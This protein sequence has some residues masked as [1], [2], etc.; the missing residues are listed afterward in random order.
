MCIISNLEN[1]NKAGGRHTSYQTVFLTP[2]RSSRPPHPGLSRLLFWA[3]PVRESSFHLKRTSWCG[4]EEHTLS[5]RGATS[6][7]V[8]QKRTW[9]GAD[10]ILNF[11][12][13]SKI[14]KSASP[15]NLCC[16]VMFLLHGLFLPDF[17]GRLDQ[18]SWLQLVLLKSRI[19]SRCW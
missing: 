1:R 6:G 3:L 10:L 13:G 17:C 15:L 2:S 4:D 5:T 19:W 16:S 7:S 9:T 18:P 14:V 12:T 8:K 11:L